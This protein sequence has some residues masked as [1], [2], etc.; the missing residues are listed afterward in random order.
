VI[1][2]HHLVW[3]GDQLEPEQ[4]N[5]ED[6]SGLKVGERVARALATTGSPEWTELQTSSGVVG[7]DCKSVWVEPAEGFYHSTMI[8]PSLFPPPF[9]SFPNVRTPK[10]EKSENRE[11]IN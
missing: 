4:E 8:S 9:S 2:F 3:N 10:V 5:G 6:D 11:G 7:V 1:P